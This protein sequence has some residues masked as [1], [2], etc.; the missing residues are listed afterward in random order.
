M[1][2]AAMENALLRSRPRASE[3]VLPGNSS[4][5][6]KMLSVLFSEVL[7]SS[8]GSCP[9]VWAANQPGTDFDICQSG[10]RPSFLNPWTN[11][12]MAIFLQ[13]VSGWFGQ[14]TRD[15]P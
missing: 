15:T 9:L 5:R 10:I 14:I 8:F 13:E 12:R 1:L 11:F 4:L 7:F 2:F 3:Q 6:L